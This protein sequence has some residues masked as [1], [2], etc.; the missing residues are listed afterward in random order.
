MKKDKIFLLNLFV[1]IVVLLACFITVKAFNVSGDVCESKVTLYHEVPLPVMLGG[2]DNEVV[3]HTHY[4]VGYNERHEQPNWVQYMIT[5]K[6]VQGTTQRESSFVEDTEVSTKSAKSA[7]YNKSGYDRGHI[8]PAADMRLDTRCMRETFLMS[9][10]SPQRHQF[11]AGIWLDLE[12]YVRKLTLEND[13]LYV[14]SGGVLK[15][16]LPKIKGAYNEVSIPEHFYKIVYKRGCWMRGWLVPHNTNYKNKKSVDAYAVSVD[17]IEKV[18]GIDF[19]QG[20]P[21][22]NEFER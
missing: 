15:D 4:V 16:D 5:R 7:D 13:T 2:Q 18:T 1:V 9:N 10:I 20:I 11:N 19:F 17:S 3:V 14:V 8:C 6:H 22:E 21:N 12:N